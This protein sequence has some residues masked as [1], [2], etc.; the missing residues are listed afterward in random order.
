[1]LRSINPNTEGTAKRTHHVEIELDTP[2][3]TGEV[4]DSP[5]VPLSKCPKFVGEILAALGATG[6]E[7]VTTRSGLRTDLSDALGHHACLSGCTE[8]LR[9][10]ARRSCGIA[11]RGR[12]AP[13]RRAGIGTDQ[14][15]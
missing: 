14:A 15:L 9:P 11:R 13:W 4:G 12:G 7:P 8:E 6:A 3:L 10:R 2:D 1:M 5:G